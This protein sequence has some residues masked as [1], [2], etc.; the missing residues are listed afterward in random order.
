VLCRNKVK[1]LALRAINELAIKHNPEFIVLYGSIVRGDYTDE[2][3]IDIACFC[4][5]PAVTKDVRI[6]EGKKLDCW[7]YKIEEAVPN[8]KDFLRFVGGEVF[9]DSNGIGRKFV[10]EITDFFNIGPDKIKADARDHLLEWSKNMLIR[11]SGDTIEAKYRK[12][13]LPCEL[14]E[15][16]F[17]LRNMWYLGSKQSFLWLQENDYS[18][19]CMF[20][21]AFSD[22]SDISVLEKL[23]SA[24]TNTEQVQAMDAKKTAPML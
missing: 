20:E 17:E 15:I 9:L 19:Y 7:V 8:R 13:W 22:P 16:Y 14:L 3:D 24:A 4:K 12:T 21:K 23:V 6:F 1:D 2:S 11:A 18:I 10:S 5:E